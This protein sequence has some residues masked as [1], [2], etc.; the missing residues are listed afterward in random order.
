MANPPPAGGG[1]LPRRGGG[2]TLYTS[3]AGVSV[4]EVAYLV[5]NDAH[6]DCAIQVLSFP[7]QSS[8]PRIDVI[9]VGEEREVSGPL[10]EIQ[11]S[12]AGGSEGS[13]FVAHYT[14]IR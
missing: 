11:V 6:S 14:R 9:D 5:R 13:E 1:G 10:R 12:G 8:T 7:P 2:R 4:P 3:G